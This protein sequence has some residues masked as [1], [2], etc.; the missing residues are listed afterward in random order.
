MKIQQ[1][2]HNRVVIVNRS[3]D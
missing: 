3:C 1:C 2:T